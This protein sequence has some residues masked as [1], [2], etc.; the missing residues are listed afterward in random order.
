MKYSNN[1]IVDQIKQ[2]KAQKN[3]QRLKEDIDIGIKLL[4]YAMSPT[5]SSLIDDANIIIKNNDMVAMDK[6]NVSQM[7][8]NSDGSLITK[9]YNNHKTKKSSNTINPITNAADAPMIYSPKAKNEYYTNGDKLLNQTVLGLNHP[10]L[11]FHNIVENDTTGKYDEYKN[12]IDA[13]KPTSAFL[14]TTLSNNFE[15][16]SNHFGYDEETNIT[17]PPVKFNSNFG[18]SDFDAVKEQRK[19]Y[20][21]SASN[22]I[23]NKIDLI[24]RTHS[25]SSAYDIQRF[26]STM[27]NLYAMD[28]G[29][30]TK[31]FFDTN[32]NNVKS[33][34]KRYKDRLPFVKTLEQQIP[35]ENR[36]P[37][38]AGSEYM[39]EKL[40]AKN[41]T[42][43]ESDTPLNDIEQMKDYVN[44]RRYEAFNMLN[45]NEQIFLR[46]LNNNCN[47]N[48]KNDSDDYFGGYR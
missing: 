1:R 27:G 16:T 14:S 37:N 47:K 24:N 4:G 7:N 48:K 38:K 39:K 9:T 17:I 45:N 26:I 33:I 13:N 46:D 2:R 40:A 34:D 20:K 10:Q 32:P 3:K 28:S 18:M 31:R 6:I 23:K 19:N 41:S 22:R 35:F 36:D 43:N 11:L 25:N 5:D 12:F 8:T 42:I 44:S 15:Y 21:P 30:D 29:A